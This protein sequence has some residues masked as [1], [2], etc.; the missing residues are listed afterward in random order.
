VNAPTSSARNSRDRDTASWISIA[1]IGA[2]MS[3][4]ISTIGL[5]PLRL[6]LPPKNIE[7]N[8]ICAA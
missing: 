6:L 5:T 1:A 3:A 4:R 8:A 2:V 7:K